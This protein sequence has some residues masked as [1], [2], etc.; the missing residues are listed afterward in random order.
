MDGAGDSSANIPIIINRRVVVLVLSLLALF[1]PM[2]CY[3]SQVAF[4]IFSATWVYIQSGY[5]VQFTSQIILMIPILA[6][7]LV[8]VYQ[9]HRYYEG[10]TTRLR[11]LLL[12]ILAEGPGVFML[13]LMLIALL[14]PSLWLYF[15]IPTPLLFLSG[16]LILWR[17]PLPEPKT[18]WNGVSGV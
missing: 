16:I 8:Y 12:G 17:R 14:V 11:T 6:L 5:D 4:Y 9:V 1:A 3:I 7:R 15:S 13:F 2:F 18:P 10:L